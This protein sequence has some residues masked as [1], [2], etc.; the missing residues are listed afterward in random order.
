MSHWVNTIG[1]HQTLCGSHVK[2]E[3]YINTYVWPLDLDVKKI[4]HFTT[5]WATVCG[6]ISL[7]M[8]SIF[9]F[10]TISEKV[11]NEHTPE[12]SPES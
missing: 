8:H 4:I 2:Y 1:N 11:G 12:K 5:V 7:E 3:F 6:V 9:I 10:Y